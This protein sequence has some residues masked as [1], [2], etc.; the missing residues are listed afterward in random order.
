MVQWPASFFF[1]VFLLF[2]GINVTF[3]L[4][5]KKHYRKY[6]LITLFLTPIPLAILFG[7]DW[8]VNEVLG[9]PFAP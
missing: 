7:T 9:I 3:K 8:Y 2:R 6:A 5:C 1:A 4:I